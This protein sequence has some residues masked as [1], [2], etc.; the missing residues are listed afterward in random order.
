LLSSL[1]YGVVAT[2]P[3]TFVVFPIGLG[4]IGLLACYLPT[5]AARRIDP[6]HAINSAD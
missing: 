5:L 4:A 3:A 1:L 2:D 6:I